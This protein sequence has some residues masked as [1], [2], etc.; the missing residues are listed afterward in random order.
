[1]PTVAVVT[2]V[3]ATLI[4]AAAAIGLLRSFGGST[5]GIM[6]RLALPTALPA[7][8]TGMR[9]STVRSMIIAIVAEM[10]GAYR[11]LGWMIYQSVQQIDF[12]AVWATIFVASLASLIFFGLISWLERRVVFWG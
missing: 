5:A 4:I 10:L 11:G 7:I 9:V 12:L 8:M 6:W 3:V 2:L 1:M